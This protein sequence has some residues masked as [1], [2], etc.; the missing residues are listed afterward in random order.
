MGP[1]RPI[2]P[3]PRMP[4]NF[5][6]MGL[7]VMDQ[8]KATLLS[9]VGHPRM[10]PQPSIGLSSLH[11]DES[12]AGTI[13]EQISYRASMIENIREQQRASLR[14]IQMLQDAEERLQ[15]APYVEPLSSAPP[16]FNRAHISTSTE[17]STEVPRSASRRELP[18][19]PVAP[20]VLDYG[21]ASMTQKPSATRSEDEVVQLTTRVRQ[22]EPSTGS[23]ISQTPG[24]GPA[25]R[26]ASSGSVPLNQ[27]TDTVPSWSGFS[28]PK[29]WK[30]T[31]QHGM[32]ETPSRTGVGS[33]PAGSFRSLYGHRRDDERT[34]P[35]QS[36][37]ESLREMDQRSE[38]RARAAMAAKWVQNDHGR[39]PPP[40]D[41]TGSE[42]TLQTGPYEYTPSSL[43]SS[44]RTAEAING[45]TE[46]AAH[47]IGGG[48]PSESGGGSSGD[49][50]SGGGDPPR[51]PTND[52]NRAPY[53]PRRGPGGGSPGGG[54]G[55]GGD[56][57]GPPSSGR[58][59]AS[60]SRSTGNGWEGG[61]SGGR[62]GQGGGPGGGGGGGPPSDHGGGHG[63]DP[64]DDEQDDERRERHR[65][66]E[67]S[68]STRQPHLSYAPMHKSTRDYKSFGHHIHDQIRVIINDYL[69]VTLPVDPNLKNL[70]L[71]TPEK[72]DGANDADV[73]LSFVKALARYLSLHG[74]GGPDREFQRAV[75]LGAYLKGRA[76][77]W[78]N[79]H[80]DI[81]RRRVTFEEIIID[82]FRRFVHT[83]TAGQAWTRYENVD[84]SPKEGIQAF[85]DEL[86]DAA[87]RL[88]QLPSE[89]EI[90]KRFM[91]R[92]PV[93]LL[94]HLH[95]V[96][97]V[98]AETTSLRRILKM[99]LEYEAA[100]YEY[101]SLQKV[102]STNSPA[103][104]AVVKTVDGQR[105]DMTGSRD[106]ERSRRENHR[107]ATDGRNRRERRWE[108]RRERR[109]GSRDRQRPTEF[110]RRDER[111]GMQP[112]SAKPDV[113]VVAKVDATGG[114]SGAR[115]GPCYTCGEYGHLANACPKGKRLH[116]MQVDESEEDGRHE[117][118]EDVHEARQAHDDG[119]ASSDD[120]EYY[121][122]AYEGHGYEDESEH[123]DGGNGEDAA[124]DAYL[125]AMRIHAMDVKPEARTF[126]TSIRRTRTIYP[127]DQTECLAAWVEIGGVKAFTLFDTGATLDAVTPGLVENLADTR[128]LFE[129]T[130][131][132]K[133]GL[134]CKGSKSSINYGA[135]LRTVVGEVDRDWYF[136]VANIAHYDA[137][138]GVPFGRQNDVV[139][140]LG[141]RKIFVGGVEIPVEEEG[142]RI[143][144]VE[145][146]VKDKKRH[147]FRAQTS[148]YT[149]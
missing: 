38:E 72:Y 93:E 19:P 79:R 17:T 145:T 106:G 62:G 91:S 107:F 29:S 27:G 113:Q 133:L 89:I 54:G 16:S 33:P 99:S 45:S 32:L 100:M 31:D 55:G 125:G 18:R 11:A 40:V 25:P 23:V 134:G 112:A 140:D 66:A 43:L 136:D 120:D 6:G 84:Y 132:V 111:R 131:P 59:D 24:A 149:R 2:V 64:S 75:M 20:P 21:S 139:V 50:G 130:E 30:N 85:Y 53:G 141:R 44:A 58:A 123:E 115:L 52:N 124:E 127:S 95:L 126:R 142:K 1:R 5:S 105:G 74:Y 9:S 129:L 26:S 37:Y 81:T 69:G 116:A 148:N 68:A 57:G 76:E 42:R 8:L 147:S 90:S 96:Q 92:L 110:R 41:M 15:N 36:R 39:M 94:K 7:P 10:I 143:A 80:V 108:D 73:F 117:E 56:G 137:I 70:R 47:P 63:G 61:A 121:A 135:R 118:D 49:S 46:Q 67:A 83:A 114:T 88:I 104:G 78:Y 98:T 12:Y 109:S 87:D 144:G 22:S 13:A 28:S 51:R 128:E 65:R 4:G 34:E 60:G 102:A 103:S 101:K 3:S 122:G 119:Y 138:L 86:M 82:L 97:R 35:Y 14:Q 48:R 77:E 71:P 146:K